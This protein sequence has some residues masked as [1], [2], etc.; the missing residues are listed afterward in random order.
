MVKTVF[1]A[2]VMNCYRSHVPAGYYDKVRGHTGVDLHYQFEPLACPITGEVIATP[3]QNQM[4]NC[5]YIQDEK[6][7]IHVFAH[8]SAFM[9]KQGDNV[10]RNQIIAK[11]GNSGNP[12]T[13]GSYPA[14]LHYEIVTAQPVNAEDAVMH[15]PEL[16]AALDGKGFNTDPLRYDR[17]LYAEFNIDP[18]TGEP[19]VVPGN[20]PKGF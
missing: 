11:T 10:T 4:G 14:H 15:R 20:D 16:T 8:L 6:G 17:A 3:H 5:L 2:A 7:A 18:T 9:V 13:G 12:P 1:D 19:I